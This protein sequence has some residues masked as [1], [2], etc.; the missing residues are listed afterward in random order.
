[1]TAIYPDLLAKIREQNDELRDIQLDEPWMAFSQPRLSRIVLE[2]NRLVRS[3]EMGWRS[4][5]D[6]NMVQL[7]VELMCATA[8]RDTK[9]TKPLSPHELALIENYVRDHLDT[10]LGLPEV[11]ELSG[12]PLHGFCRAFKAATGESFHRYT[13][14]LRL[15][16]AERL[17][18]ETEAPLAE[19]AYAT[20]FSS[21]SHFTSTMGRWRGVTPGR[22]RAD[23]W[24]A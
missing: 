12:R 20:G 10:N 21:Q 14:N 17:L 2:Q 11:A 4:L 1:M 15:E 6:A 8:Q 22:F 16:E 5:A 23:A 9:G 24:A 3:G 19:I 7:V 13:I 18:S